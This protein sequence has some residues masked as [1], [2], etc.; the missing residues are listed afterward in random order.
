MRS[1]LALNLDQLTVDSFDTSTRR[2][3]RGTV[4]GEQQ[5]TCPTACTCPGCPTCDATCDDATCAASCNG[6]CVA[7]CNGGC[8]TATCGVS[9][10]RTDCG[11]YPNTNCL[12]T[13]C[14]M[15]ECCA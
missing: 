6:T 3:P 13:G 11:C 9:C 1:K 7:S 12:N 10:Y 5:C 14:G 4:Y 15:Y 8:G 2:E